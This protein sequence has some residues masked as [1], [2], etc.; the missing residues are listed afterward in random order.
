MIAKVK[1]DATRCECDVCHY[2]WVSVSVKPPQFCQNRACRSREWNGKSKPSWV[3]EIKLP[4]PRKG[5]HGRRKSIT[6]LHEGEE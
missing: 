5:K 6:L 4:G 1:I 2:E 3:N